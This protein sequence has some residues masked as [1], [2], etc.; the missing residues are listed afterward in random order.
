MRAGELT[1]H[2]ALLA[3][4]AGCG[5]APP[6]PGPGHAARGARVERDLDPPDIFPVDLDLVVRVDIG[7]MRAGIGPAAADAL[8]GRLLQA[9]GDPQTPGQESAEPELREALASAEVVWIAARV[10]E[11]DDGDRI[12]VVEGRRSM[13]EL[14]AARWE[15]VRSFN[16]R[17]RI[18]DRI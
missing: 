1:S 12:V 13:P 18:F 10:A 11:L 3:A 16:G 6:T 14:A 17:V 8:S 5:S 15:R 7:R 4:L 2:L 9:G